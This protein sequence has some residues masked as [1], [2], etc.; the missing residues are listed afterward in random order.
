MTILGFIATAA[1]AIVLV[2][3]TFL[4]GWCLGTYW[5][6]DRATRE[7]LRKEMYRR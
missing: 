7:R 2:G 6:R 5:E 3:G 4:S 1:A